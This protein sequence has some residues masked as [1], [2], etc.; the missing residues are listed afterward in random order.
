M[1][2]I[3]AV[4]D[5]KLAE[6]AHKPLIEATELGELVFHLE[7]QLKRVK[8]ALTAA[9]WARDHDAPDVMTSCKEC[10][11]IMP[12]PK[13]GGIYVCNKCLAFESQMPFPP[14]R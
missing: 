13:R 8:G 9:R 10:G 14:S 12:T 7:L 6:A 5:E 2:R 4:V 11:G 1:D 3:K